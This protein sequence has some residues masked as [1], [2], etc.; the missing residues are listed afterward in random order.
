MC[1]VLKGIC[2]SIGIIVG[3]N[4]FKWNFLSVFDTPWYMGAGQNGSCRSQMQLLFDTL[5]RHGCRKLI[6]DSF[7]CDLN[8]TVQVI[9]L[10]QFIIRFRIIH[11]SSAVFFCCLDI[12]VFRMCIHN[13]METVCVM[14]QY[15]IRKLHVS[16]RKSWTWCQKNC[17]S[18]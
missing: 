17:E 12:F 7:R 8:F 1:I 15:Q 4:I 9:I 5:I 13:M 18:F 11:T 6:A 16:L 2:I 3:L 14:L 10:S